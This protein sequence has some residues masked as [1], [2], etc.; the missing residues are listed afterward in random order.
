[1]S[2]A[3]FPP[4][5]R[6]LERAAR[7]VN[8]YALEG[9]AESLSQIAVILHFNATTAPLGDEAHEKSPLGGSNPNRE[10]VERRSA[11]GWTTIGVY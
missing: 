2:P 7:P 11:D 8:L 9:R 1:L 6:R 3:L 5:N 10:L 4:P